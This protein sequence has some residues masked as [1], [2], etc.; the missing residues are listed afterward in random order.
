MRYGMTL[1]RKKMNILD[2]QTLVNISDPAGGVYIH[3]AQDPWNIGDP[4]QN[5]NA[6]PPKQRERYVSFSQ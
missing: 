6:P 5:T 1:R 4:C 3:G 2:E